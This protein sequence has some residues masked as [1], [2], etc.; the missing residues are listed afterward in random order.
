MNYE[1][2][3]KVYFFTKNIKITRPY[4]KLDYKIIGLYEIVGQISHLYKLKLPETSRINNVFYT[5]FLK[6]AAKDPLPG[7]ELVP[8]DSIIIDNQ[9]E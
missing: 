4:K 9:E 3:N 5:A 8:A 6:I 7:Q 2:G 1:I